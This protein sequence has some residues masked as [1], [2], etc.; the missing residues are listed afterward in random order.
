MKVTYSDPKLALLPKSSAGYVAKKKA[1]V[2]PQSLSQRDMMDRAMT[3]AFEHAKNTG[4]LGIGF[5]GEGPS[6]QGKTAAAKA[7]TKMKK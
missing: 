7:L 3:S 5:G 2:Y 6:M 4:K 1:G